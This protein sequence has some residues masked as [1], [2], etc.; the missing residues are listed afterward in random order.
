M[1][2][3]L[4]TYLPDSST[5]QVDSDGI[6]FTEIARGSLVVPNSY[7]APNTLPPAYQFMHM[8]D[9]N[10]TGLGVDRSDNPIL[11][12]SSPLGCNYVLA[13]AQDGNLTYRFLCEKNQT[14]QWRLFTTKPPSPDGFGLML[15]DANGSLVFNSNVPVLKPVTSTQQIGRFPIPPGKSYMAVI[16]SFDYLYHYEYWWEEISIGDYADY[17]QHGFSW[18]GVRADSDYIYVSGEMLSAQ[19]DIWTPTSGAPKPHREY[20]YQSGFT[21]VMIIDVTHD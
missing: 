4:L 20:T 19:I 12:V 1:P 5:V 18:G 17:E 11:A 3:G 14:I 6:Y 15:Y 7:N 8:L 21:Q 9:L 13:R 2:S 10:I 16:S